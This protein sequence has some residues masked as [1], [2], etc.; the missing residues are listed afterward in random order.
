MSRR[1]NIYE[2]NYVRLEAILGQA[3]E[4][5]TPAK[6]YT[7]R[8]EGFMDLIVEN[9]G[10]CPWLGT[11]LL[12]LAHYHVVNGDLCQDPELVIRIYPPRYLFE[13]L[14]P[15][16]DNQFGRVEVTE[17]QQAIP[18][19]SQ[20]VYPQ[21]GLYNPVLK[22]SLNAFLSLWLRNLKVQGHTLIPEPQDSTED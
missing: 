10:M 7:F 22:Q 4:K 18:P 19:I 13:A 1:K 5:I 8:A 20:K 6:S 17:F 15:S 2:M 11:P 12:S 16:T 3:P 9:I 21:P 14:V